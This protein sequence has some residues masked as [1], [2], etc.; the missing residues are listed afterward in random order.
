MTFANILNILFKYWKPV[1]LIISCCL[2]VGIC[3]WIICSYYFLKWCKLN[4]DDHYFCL[5][6]YNKKC[7]NI[8][9]K[10]GNIPIKNIYLI[11]RPIS[12]FTNLFLILITLGKYK[13]DVHH[14]GILVELVENN[15]SVFI[16]LEKNNC[17]NLS[18]NFSF[19]TSQKIKNI[20]VKKNKYKLLDILDITRKR[21]GDDKFFN[22]R[23]TNNNCQ[24]FILELLKTINKDSK[25]N[26]KYV[27][28][29]SLL[30]KFVSSH[31]DFT[32]HIVH[33]MVNFG[34]I[35]ED[36]IGYTVFC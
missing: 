16:I 28:Q 27:Y 20:K 22:W 26:K 36:I 17:V 4:I 14:T 32:K 31:P 19:N 9:E 18:T 29:K 34:N 24:I 30:N 1:L 21:L 23:L 2:I 5:N 25:K 3:V 13:S 7:L 15:E 8:L 6:N 33:S 10:Y 12:V 11:K 35:I